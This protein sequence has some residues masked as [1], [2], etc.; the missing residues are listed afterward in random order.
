MWS[1][2]SEHRLVSRGPG[3]PRTKGRLLLDTPRF[4][5]ILAAAVT[6]VGEQGR[7]DEGAFEQLLARL[8]AAGL[9][10]VYVC[11]S[12]GEG[13]LQRV[14]Q[15]KAVAEAAVRLSPRGAQV[16]VH[17]GASSLEDAA[18]LARHA[19]RAGACAVSS[20]PPLGGFTFAEIRAYYAAVAGAVGIPMFVYY[21]PEA[22]PTV[23]SRAQL[24]ELC[25]L[26][27]VAGVKLTDFDLFRLWDLKDHGVTVFNGRDEVLTM[28]LLSGADGAI[29]TSYNV[30]PG[31]A[32][33]IYRLARSGAWAE[34]R[35]EQ[36]KLNRLIR[37]AQAFPFFAAVK[38]ILT[39]SGIDCGPPIAP[40]A[41]LTGEEAARLREEVETSG[42]ADLL[43][44]PDTQA[45]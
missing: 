23:M 1:G 2:A 31:V 42:L 28:G 10:G 39:W 17:V 4:H 43:L 34:A 15:R 26:R 40:H 45:G 14:E 19:E 32:A 5:G 22:H 36:D 20:L 7:F 37:I 3:E 8:Y 33:R 24:L 21:F 27:N 13:T 30:L 29:G 35:I 11:G 12:T 16:I 9:D 44:H 18:E 41:S 6:P 38:Q 25:A